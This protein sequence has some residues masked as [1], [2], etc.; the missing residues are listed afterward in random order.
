MIRQQK[1][2]KFPGGKITS[3]G[4]KEGG[5]DLIHGNLDEATWKVVQD[6][7]NKIITG[8]LKVAQKVSQIK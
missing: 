1:E 2:N 8:D 4:L 3:Y 5:M 7:R 6:Y